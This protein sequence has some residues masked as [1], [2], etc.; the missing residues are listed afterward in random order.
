[1]ET[2]TGLEAKKL[3]AEIANLNK[4]REKLN[5]EVK[6]AAWNSRVGRYATLVIPTVTALL[7][8]LGIIY[9]A[10]QFTINHAT[11][12]TKFNTQLAQDSAMK[13]QER[14]HDFLKT[15]STFQSTTYFA[16]CQSAATIA[17]LPAKDPH[18]QAA[19]LK[20]I[21][22]YR[23]DALIVG[24]GTVTQAMDRFYRC[25]HDSDAVCVAPA[26]KSDELQRRSRALAE[27]CRASMA[28]TSETDINDLEKFKTLYQPHPVPPVT[29]E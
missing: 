22:L 13:K 21:Q 24:N 4:E 12:Q 29:G 3:Q 5:W 11:D 10:Y 6:D 1:M 17:V 9:G 8:L 7:T 23:G 18:N 14:E 20:F 19:Q 15:F 27:A 28:E 16:L 2:G 25:L 26:G